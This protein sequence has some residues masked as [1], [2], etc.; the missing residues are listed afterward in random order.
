MA[1]LERTEYGLV[2]TSDGWFVLNAADARWR[3]RDGRGLL[4]ELEGEL[5]FPQIGI[6]IQVLGPGEPMAMYHWEADQEDFLVVYGEAVLVIE[7]EE[8]PLRH[9][10]FVHCPGRAAHT[11]IGAGEGPCVIVAVG[12]RIDTRGDNWGAYPVD[13]TA[14]RHGASADEA[15]SEPKTAYARFGPS[16]SMAYPPGTL[17]AA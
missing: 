11:I 1:K 13:E 7:G 8:Q 15:T 17:P 3:R 6:N 4:C 12:A 10:D 16:V 9:W 2:P 5:D 14:R